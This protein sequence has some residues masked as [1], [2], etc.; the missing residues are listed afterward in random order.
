MQ[1]PLEH[2]SALRGAVVGA[3]Q[4]A[5]RCLRFAG[6]RGGGVCRVCSN[7]GSTVMLLLS[8]AGFSSRPRRAGAVGIDHP[9]SAPAFERD[10]TRLACGL[11]AGGPLAQRFG[12][13][14]P[15][16]R[17]VERPLRT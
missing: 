6:G 7:R 5:Q 13:P 12:Q 8:T 16:G 9:R 14:A 1:G 3:G 2:A 17:L 10:G 15:H 11:H 4:A